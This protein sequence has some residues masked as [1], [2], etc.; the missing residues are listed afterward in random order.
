VAST[1]TGTLVESFLQ[2]KYK[3]ALKL[4]GEV[5]QRSAFELFEHERRE[6]A[7]ARFLDTPGARAVQDVSLTQAVLARGIELIVRSRLDVDGVSLQF[8][9]LRRT[10]GSSSLGEFHYE[11]VLVLAREKVAAED[12]LLLGV[13]SLLLE[14]MQGR[15]SLSGRIIHGRDGKMSRVSLPV[16]GAESVMAGIRRL[17]SAPP[18]MVLN[19]HCQVCEFQV[20]CLAQA[21]REDDISLL[22]N[23][24]EKEIRNYNRRGIFTLTQLS[25]DFRL[26][27]DKSRRSEPRRYPALQA[28]AIRDKKV[29]VLG[30]PQIPNSPVRIYL[31]LEGDPDRDFVYLVGMIV[32]GEDLREQH[33]FWIDAKEEE[34]WLLQEFA[35]VVAR[36]EEYLVFHYGSYEPAFFRRMAKQGSEF[37]QRIL[38]RC[39]NVLSVVYRNVYFP[40][41]SNGLKE[42]GQFLGFSW[43]SPDA[44]GVQSLVW[45]RRWEES[46]EPGLK[47]QLLAYNRDDCAALRRVTEFLS[48]SLSRERSVPGAT[49][50][51]DVAN[52]DDLSGAARKADWNKRSPF[53]P[54]FKFIN[55]CAYFDYQ[56]ERVFVRTNKTL[57]RIR[58]QA[59]PHKRRAYRVNHTIEFRL[60]HCP[61]CHRLMRKLKDQVR[62]KLILDLRVTSAGITRRVT[63][64]SAAVFFCARCKTRTRPE[65]FRR[66]GRYGHA[67]RSWALYQHVVY[68]TSFDRV[69]E[70]F[71]ELFGLRVNAN[72]IADFKEL[73]ASYYEPTYHAMLSRLLSGSLVHADETEVKLTKGKKGYVWVLAGLE[74][75]VYFYRPNRE[76]KFLKDMFQ[77]FKGVLVTDFYGAYESLG[78]PKQKC[79]VHLM[80]D[81]NNDLLR[82]PFDEEFKSLVARFS[83]LLR[84]IVTTIDRR[85][86]KRHWLTKHRKQV[87]AFFGQLESGPYMSEVAEAYRNRFLRHRETL[88]TFLEYDG[89]P[90]N[91]SNAE[92]A[93]RRFAHYR[94]TTVSLLTEAGLTEYLLLLSILQTC[95][96]RGLGFLPF[97]LSGQTDLESFARCPNGKKPTDDAATSPG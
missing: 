44:S 35:R 19:D 91:N 47:E 61:V 80:R 65:A 34:G 57:E 52:V 28:I 13:Q 31:D 33:S 49:D 89:V 32:E 41:L 43:A 42:I 17:E 39:F 76:G 78:C 30:S 92:H 27:R 29:L 79:L 14:G 96:S 93:I 59:T 24:G 81:L 23:L 40:T 84:D 82:S 15:R 18:K 97:L 69:S 4:A 12:K 83:G 71:A 16:D 46:R 66:I 73:A 8:D 74:D 63:R 6:A 64:C 22:R 37:C 85:G 20:R 67:L 87:A 26:R 55:K 25:R 60:K 9:A 38:P 36:H 2:C 72:D 95:K 3:A 56:R 86:L 7:L 68:R 5:G 75:V 1:I 62:H 54:D 88:F 21:H 10:C 94:E 51:P 90:W 50:G 58:K 48:E 45:R 53:F 77:E 70:M 11:P